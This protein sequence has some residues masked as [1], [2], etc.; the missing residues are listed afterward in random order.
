MAKTN[1]IG[2]RFRTEILD[3][4]KESVGANT[5]QQVLVFLENFYR[6]HHDKISVLDALRGATPPDDDF[7]VKYEAITAILRELKTIRGETL[8]ANRKTGLGPKSW[9]LEQNNKIE[10]LQKKLLN[11]E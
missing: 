6:Q 2:V 9:Q 4:I 7:K 8:P 1:P 10:A 3:F 5:P 11:F